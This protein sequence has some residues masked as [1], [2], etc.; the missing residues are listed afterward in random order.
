MSY[1]PYSG[2]LRDSTTTTI[3]T[4]TAE[5]EGAVMEGAGEGRLRSGF[6][7]T[8]FVCYLIVPWKSHLNIIYK[9][10]SYLYR[11]KYFK[12]GAM[13]EPIIAHQRQ[14][15][16]PWPHAPE[17]RPSC[18]GPPL[19]TTARDW[20]QYS[21]SP[22]IVETTVVKYNFPILFGLRPQWQSG[23]GRVTGGAWGIKGV[24]CIG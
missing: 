14:F 8:K 7:F 13:R 3:T 22:T 19:A 6:S 1:V 24:R 20:Q 9:Y 17:H 2:C 16:I 21:T 18:A 12:C 10:Y 23:N 5:G 4:S 15:S 11:R